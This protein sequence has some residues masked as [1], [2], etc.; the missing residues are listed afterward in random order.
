[1]AKSRRKA[2]RKAMPLLAA[3]VFCENFLED[4]DGV[5]SLIRV[6][7][8]LT[9]PKPPE[10]PPATEA[11]SPP[12]P[13]VIPAVPIIAVLAFRSGDAKGEYKL[14]TD[15]VMPSGKKLKAKTELPLTFLGGENGINVRSNITAPVKEEGV[16]WYEVRLEGRLITRM[17]LRIVHAAPSG[18]GAS[19][20]RA[21]GAKK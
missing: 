4:K 2:Q 21:K 17:P 3:A 20:D 6:F 14:R 10:Q 1:M 5:V 12:V 13:N 7:E 9:V 19:P 8:T 11:K 15:V 18:E 16:Y